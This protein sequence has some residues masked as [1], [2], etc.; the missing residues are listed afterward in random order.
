MGAAPAPAKSGNSK[1]FLW[2]GMLLVLLAVVG[3]LAYVAFRQFV[4]RG[5][6]RLADIQQTIADAGLD[7]SSIPEADAGAEPAAIPEE[8]APAPE[9]V[10]PEEPVDTPAREPVVTPQ[11]PPARAETPA[12][13]VAPAPPPKAAPR[14]TPTAKASPVKAPEPVVAP[15][16][17]PVQ[18]PPPKTATAPAV[19]EPA[20]AKT[21]PAQPPPT[22]KGSKVM[23]S[24]SD[25]YSP[26][27]APAAATAPAT[28]A[29]KAAPAATSGDV[30]WNGTLKKNQTVTVDFAAGSADAGGQPLPGKPVRLETFSPVIE[31][32]ELPGPEN[33][34][35]RFSFRATRD[36]K[37]NVTLNFHWSLTQ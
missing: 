36:A 31:I 1:L 8:I 28:V 35:K 26:P 10:V 3:G 16:P 11:P 30:F 7:S 9:N 21:E 15:T 24:G 32:I 12:P 33:G 4:Q 14:P 17:P 25:A 5:Q 2:M 20:P 37:K 27:A 29:P 19:S 18:A 13:K 23:L 6:D 34:W 22:P